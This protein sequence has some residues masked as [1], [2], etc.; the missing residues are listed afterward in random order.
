MDRGVSPGPRGQRYKA[1]TEFISGEPT[2]GEARLKRVSQGLEDQSL[3]NGHGR[4]E[5]L[6][7]LELGS[8]NI[9]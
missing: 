5:R 7:S 2:T 6:V 8:I 1:W 4:D 3:Y 9:Y